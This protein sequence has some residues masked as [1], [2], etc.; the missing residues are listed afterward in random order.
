[1][2]QSPARQ[3]AKPAAALLRSLRDARAGGALLPTPLLED[4]PRSLEDAYATAA[5]L[6]EG[7]AIAG[8]KIG[9]TSKRAQAMLGLD[10]PFWGAVLESAFH[11]SPAEL[12]PQGAPFEAEP[13]IV[14][15][16]DRTLDRSGMDIRAAV[17]SACFGLEVNRPSF[18]EP[19]AAGALCLI[20]DNGVNHALVVGSEIAG[21]RERELADLELKLEVGAASVRGTA[22]GSG[23]DP[24]EALAWL[25][26][27]KLEARQPLQ[28]GEY[29][30]TG[31][32]GGSVAIGSS[33]T[34]HTVGEVSPAEERVTEGASHR[35]GAGGSPPPSGP[36]RSLPPPPSSSG[37]GRS[38]PEVLVHAD[39][40]VVV[41]LRIRG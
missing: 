5:A 30:A 3:T 1:M 39:G 8:W 22:R 6:I 20:A 38:F 36:L 14:F 23:F 4:Q 16:L 10:Q 28:A 13:E 32:I 27:A 7:E 26:E 2:T 19:F 34:G 15:R 41:R 33:P 40:E 11:S 9:A 17:G 18:A 31:S 37:Q 29:V 24:W 12:S 25:A 35:H 21:W